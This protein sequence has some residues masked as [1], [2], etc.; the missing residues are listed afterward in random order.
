MYFEFA[1][2]SFK[3]ISF[4][5][6]EDNQKIVMGILL[7]WDDIDFFIKV[8][9]LNQFLKYF[10]IVY[11]PEDTIGIFIYKIEGIII[12]IKKCLVEECLFYILRRSD[13]I[14]NQIM[15]KQFMAYFK[16]FWF[17]PISAKK[18]FERFIDSLGFKAH[19]DLFTRFKSSQGIDI[20]LSVMKFEPDASDIMHS[21][22]EKF[23]Y[24][25][26]KYMLTIMQKIICSVCHRIDDKSD[27]FPKKLING[28]KRDI[29]IVLNA[30]M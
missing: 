1:G 11:L 17:V 8:F 22:M 20:V 23:F 15:M 24:P 10:F 16:W 30:I 19:S 7:K 29:F 27:I 14:C 4:L 9:T 2:K 26:V 5:I 21:S 12:K 25:I 6:F 3:N 28:W 18:F 13:T